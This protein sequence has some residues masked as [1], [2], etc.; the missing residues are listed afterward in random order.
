VRNPDLAGRPDQRRVERIARRRIGDA[1]RAVAAAEGVVA[2]AL[3]ALHAL[4]EGQDISVAPARI[5]HLRPGVEVLRLA[6]HE[7]EAVDRAGAAQ[8]PPARHWQAAAVGAGLR[9]AAVEPVDRG[10]GDQL[11]VADGDA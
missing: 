2:A 6:A 8:H 3:V 7:G 9:L 11:R 1:E 5:A 10:V 4:E